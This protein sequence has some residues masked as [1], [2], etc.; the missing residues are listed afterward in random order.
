MNIIH[1][2]TIKTTPKRLYTALTTSKGISGWWTPKAKAVP[3]VGSTVEVTFSGGFEVS[4]RV[5]QLKPGRRV[6]WTAEQVPPAWAGSQISFDLKKEG[7]MVEFTF[8]HAGVSQD[9]SFFNFCWA[10]YVRSIKLLV[11]TGKG[12]PRGTRASD[13]W[14]P[15]E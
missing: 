8:T 1:S 12:E 5:K 11:E 3:K 7:R 13:A 10:Q 6:V 4:F 15:L 9:Y 2:I 14:H